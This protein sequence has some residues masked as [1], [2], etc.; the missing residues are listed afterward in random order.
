MAAKVI[1]SGKKKIQ[2]I[3]D[4]YRYYKVNGPRGNK[5]TCNFRCV[6]ETCKSTAV[7]TGPISEEE[8]N[9]KY[10]NSPKNPHNHPQ[11]FGKTVNA[12]ILH[13]FRAAA[14][15]GP[16]LSS[17]SLYEKITVEKLQSLTSPERQQ[18]GPHLDPHHKIRDQYYRITADKYPVFKTV[19]EVDMSALPDFES[20]TVFRKPLYRGRTSSY[21]HFFMADYGI[22]AAAECESL[23]IDGTFSTC[24]FPFYQ[25]ITLLGKAGGKVYLLGWA[26]LPNKQQSTYKDVL[27][28]MRET[29]SE[30]GV[31]LDF[32]FIYM[33]G[34]RAIINA[35]KAVFEDSQQIIC[36]FHI[37]DAQR[38]YGG[39]Q[40]ADLVKK[41]KDLKTFYLRSKKIFFL[42]WEVWPTTWRLMKEDLEPE[43]LL[44]PEVTSYIAYMEKNYIPTSLPVRKK[45]VLYSPD[46]TCLW[47]N[48][49]GTV[50]NNYSESNNARLRR[51]LGIHPK[52][53]KFLKGMRQEAGAQETEWLRR[54]IPGPKKRKEDQEKFSLRKKWRAAFAERYA[55]GISDE[56]LL[57]A[58][59]ELLVIE[60]PSHSNQRFVQVFPNR[61]LGKGRGPVR[62]Q[63][64]AKSRS[65]PP[66]QAKSPTTI[67]SE[68]SQVM[69][70]S[71]QTSPASSPL[72]PRPQ[73][74]SSSNVASQVSTESYIDGSLSSM[75]RSI[76]KVSN[77]SSL[78]DDVFQEETRPK[79]VLDLPLPSDGHETHPSTNNQVVGNSHR[80]VVYSSSDD[81]SKSESSIN[82]SKKTCLAQE[83]SPTKL[84]FDSEEK[85]SSLPYPKAKS[86]SPLASPPRKNNKNKSQK[87]RK[88]P[89]TTPLD[90]VCSYCG[91][92]FANSFNCLRH[93][94]R[95][96][97][98][99]TSYGTSKQAAGSLQIPS[100]PAVTRSLRIGKLPTVDPVEDVVVTGQSV[101]EEKVYSF[102]PINQVWQR[103]MAFMFGKD[104]PMRNFYEEMESAT[105]M[106]HQYP[107]ELKNPAGDGA[108]LP[109]AISLAIWGNQS[110]HQELRDAAVNVLLSGPLP[111]ETTPRGPNFEAEM[112][113]MRKR[114]TYMT[115]REVEAFA[116]LLDTP[117]FTCVRTKMGGTERYFWQRL[118]HESMEDNV[119]NQRG[120]YLL[121]AK[122]HFQLVLR[123]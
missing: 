74:S 94:N 76:G 46:L 56:E 23:F 41:K 6:I 90:R 107:Q 98:Q 79:L 66:A 43:T 42:R 7:T 117:I 89:A 60:K 45:S 50:T 61:K 119:D 114:T 91:Q 57:P 92:K 2:L 4:G 37:S 1:I 35:S 65:T 123:P 33:D 14:K 20:Q 73:R 100:S 116:Y 64:R 97:K 72:H 95:I 10:H 118:P 69:E 87:K 58:L 104:K 17:K 3:I 70:G 113:E 115:T 29:C 12:E 38:R 63:T 85:K 8:V 82:P 110:H 52:F 24:P 112:K 59:D 34:E 27:T 109:R 53:P 30:A 5:D 39:N 93:E 13:E 105:A 111:G 68:D 80:L 67:P 71:Q 31:D 18:I 77:V 81:D 103:Q 54:N 102:L 122:D 22:A 15:E 28:M 26:L 11:H 55:N 32:S 40:M 16:Q 88:I 96:H 106:R 101:T 21:A 51:Q 19:E 86:P 62:G 83:N 9:V 48:D 47:E 25:T 78:S 44:L 99:D 84:P 120:I 121:N 49:D 108:C 75:E 36:H